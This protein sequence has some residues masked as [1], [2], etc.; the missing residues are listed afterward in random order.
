M[1]PVTSAA[2]GSGSSADARQIGV[3]LDGAFAEFVAVP[4]SA[5]HRLSDGMT[6]QKGAYVEPLACVLHGDERAAVA[7]S[8]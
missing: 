2:I 4:A 7:P 8:R 6:A 5:V 1:G 3:H